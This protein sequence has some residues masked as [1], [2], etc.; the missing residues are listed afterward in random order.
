MLRNVTPERL[1]AL[2]DGVFAVLI[3][4]LVLELRPPEQFTFQ[5]LLGLWH[6]WLSYA[7]SYLFIA[8]VWI[9]HH[10]LLSHAEKVT[11]RLIWF[12]FACLFSISFLPFSTAWMAASH[13]A[14]QPV[15]FYAAASF[16]VNATY[17]ALIQELIGRSDLA[18]SVRKAMRIRALVTL[19]LFAVAAVVA[20]KFP[21]VCLGICLCCFIS[22]LTP[23]PLGRKLR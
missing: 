4:I 1:N 7:L 8:V 5:A 14:P 6:S 9:N 18:A 2:T 19:G 13:L 12:N 21:L 3:T 10:Y 22:Y 17:A 15:A 11:P 20:L 16:V 23:E